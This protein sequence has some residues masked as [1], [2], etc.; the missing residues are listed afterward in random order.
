MAF[1]SAANATPA[2]SPAVPDKFYSLAAAA[3]G[4]PPLLF[5][6]QDAASFS[7][8]ADGGATWA[9]AATPHDF[10]PQGDLVVPL[11]DGGAA[12]P[13]PRRAPTTASA[14]P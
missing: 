12:T 5:G 11:Y 1:S 2:R 7:V 14:A 4:S 3:A 8:S 10:T 13:P 6:V 9:A